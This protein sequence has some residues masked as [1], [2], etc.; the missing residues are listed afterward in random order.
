MQ[1]YHAITSEA[2]PLHCNRD[3]I[4]SAQKTRPAP[5]RLPVSIVGVCQGRADNDDM[6]FTHQNMTMKT[7]FRNAS[8]TQLAAALQDA[9]NY[10]LAL[11]DRFQSSGLADVARV[12][13]LPIINPPLWELGHIAWFAEWFVLR[14]AATS[15]LAAAQY[16]CLLQA[17]DRWFDSGNVAHATRWTLDLPDTAAIKKYADEVLTRILDKLARVPDDAP[18][19][20]PYRLVLAHEDMHGEAFAYTLQTLGLSAP[21]QLAARTFAPAPQT[22]LHF[23]GGTFQLGSPAIHEFVFD[24]E[25]WTH[26]VTL[27]AFSISSTLV[28]NVEYQQFMRDGGYEKTQFWSDAGRAWRLSTKR[29][30]PRYWQRDGELWLCKRFDTLMELPDE[31]PVRHLSLHE[32]LAYCRWA[33]RRLSSEAEWEFAALS[34]HPDF[35]WG[36]LWEWT[37]SPFEPYPGFSADAYLEYSAPWFGTHQVLRGASYAT[38]PRIRSPRYRNFFMPVRD[39]IFVGFRTCAIEPAIK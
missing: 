26:P 30:A 19:L 4:I 25:K 5:S 39:D 20:Y 15:H 11:F 29:L 32:A 27:P 38:Q 31:E 36:D 14:E 9:R 35:H 28:S 24:N 13:Y 8:P 33:G 18:A 3:A 7:S 16:P 21:P 37:R 12:P 22:D 2:I 34:E 10:T 17:G 23:D 6:G 1:C